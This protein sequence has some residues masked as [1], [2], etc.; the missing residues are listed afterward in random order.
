MKPGYTI[1][2]SPPKDLTGITDTYL[3]F[4]WHL[5]QN[6]PAPFGDPEACRFAEKVGREIIRRFIEN[7]GPELWVVQG[8]HIGS[9]AAVQKGG[10]A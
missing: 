9:P 10:A 6:N 5:S 1:T 7:V 8:A 3:V 2:I 4:L